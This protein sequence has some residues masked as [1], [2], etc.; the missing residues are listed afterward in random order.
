MSKRVNMISVL[1]AAAIALGAVIVV[2]LIPK[3]ED[4]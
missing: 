1:I 4:E 3:K 2:M